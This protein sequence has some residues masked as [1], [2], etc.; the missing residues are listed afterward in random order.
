MEAIEEFEHNG[1]TVKIYYDNDASSPRD[2][3]ELGIMLANGHRRY[4]LGDE[5]FLS[6][7]NYSPARLRTGEYEAAAAAL[8]HYAERRKIHLFPRWCKIHLGSTV[9]LPLGLIDHSGIS[10]YVGGGAHPHDPGGWD[11]GLVGFIF[12]TAATREQIGTDPEHIEEA[13]RAEV[14]VYDE[15]LTGQ[16]YGYLVEDEDGDEVGSCWGMFGEEYVK[17]SGRDAAGYTCRNCNEEINRHV[18]PVIDEE[19]DTDWLH[20]VCV[21]CGGV[22]EWGKEGWYHL[23][24]DLE[25][26]QHHKA[27][28]THRKRCNPNLGDAYAVPAQEVGKYE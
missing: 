25:S 9:V 5:Q 15:Y 14:K 2:A 12:D 3:D 24:L 26:S 20:T 23:H 7:N 8:E 13:L 17:Q 4:T 28:V 18:G 6:G 16:V 10:M 19:V 1:K 22:I 11:S 27:E 21:T